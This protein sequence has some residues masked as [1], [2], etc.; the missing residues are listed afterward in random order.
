MYGW[1]CST[2]DKML[3]QRARGP[4]FS[5]QHPPPKQKKKEQEKN[6]NR[7][8]Q[9]IIDYR[10]LLECHNDKSSHLIFLFSVRMCWCMFC[11]FNKSSELNQVQSW[12]SLTYLIHSL[13]HHWHS[14]FCPLSLYVFFISLNTHLSIQ[15]ISRCVLGRI[16]NLMYPDLNSKTSEG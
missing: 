8:W 1:G 14:V 16:L 3:A 4:G 7:Y 2:H 9:F 13:K 11:S 12:C 10:F 5:S 6:V 15:N